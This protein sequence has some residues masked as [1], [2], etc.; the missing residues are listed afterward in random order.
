[1]TR[2]PRTFI[3]TQPHGYIDYL[4]EPLK[5]NPD[6]FFFRHKRRKGVSA[7]IKRWLR[8]VLPGRHPSLW[9]SDILGHH[10]VGFLKNVRPGDRLILWDVVN[11]KDVRIIMEAVPGC[12][13]VSML[14]NPLRQVC[15]RSAREMATYAPYMRG[16]GVRPCTFDPEDAQR[17]GLV[18]VGQT[19][20]YPS[21][22]L[23][24]AESSA[25]VFFIGADKGR[26]PRLDT[27]AARL[28]SEGISY[29]FMLLYG[30]HTQ[31]GRYPRLDRCAMPH[32][33]PYPEVLS[34]SAGAD[35]LLEIVQNH[36]S[37]LTW[38]VL[39]ALF[40]A[41]KLITDNL[42]VKD[43]AFYCPE[44]IYI[45]DD[46][47]QPWPTLK[48]FLDAPVKPVPRSVTDSYDIVNWIGRLTS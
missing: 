37:G 44:N 47:N 3:I 12:E 21:D 20:R 43:E 38:R 25:R 18:Y 42:H 4:F 24:P 13:A 40:L 39:E 31:R 48:A 1:M 45:I 27:I 17:Y 46:P 7:A 34:I 22:K 23:V 36:Q 15:H 29:K 35:C 16:L 30:K 28:E 11:R 33:V 19:Y 9:T 41:K 14:W 6:F 5:K 8:S 2:H 32:S 26:L 10:Y